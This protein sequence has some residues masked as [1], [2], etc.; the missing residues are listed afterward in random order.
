MKTYL[1]FLLAST[2]QAIG[3]GFRAYF[4]FSDGFPP[5]EIEDLQDS[6]PS[7]NVSTVSTE[8]EASATADSS[9]PSDSTGY[10]SRAH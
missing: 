4:T 2:M 3:A 10:A 5:P 8:D 6:R 9:L 1:G 7:E